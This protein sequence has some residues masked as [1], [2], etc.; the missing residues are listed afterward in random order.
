[1]K[2]IKS[3]HP[4]ALTI[5]IVFFSTALLIVVL[6]LLFHP[7]RVLGMNTSIFY[8]DEKYTLASYFSV[9]TAFLTGFL[10]L[11]LVF[12][13]SNPKHKLVN[14]IFS[15]FF[16]ILSFDE[17]FEVHEHT[18]SIIKNI[19]ETDNFFGN[20][21]HLSWIFP[22]SIIIF[23]T[24][25]LFIKKIIFSPEHIKYPLM[26]GFGCFA[27]VIVF[28]LL[29]SAAYGQSIYLYYVAIE[30]GLE[31]IGVTFFLLAVLVESDYPASVWQSLNKKIG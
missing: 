10:S 26:A 12:P 6:H 17:Y 7:V 4:Q 15:L 25:Y 5:F 8:M 23:L 1:M 18:N 30:E 27:L 14:F 9:I 19:F 28:E 2:S 16:L 11:T 20:L 3:H 31:M 29:G 24:F 21:A 13:S 22:L